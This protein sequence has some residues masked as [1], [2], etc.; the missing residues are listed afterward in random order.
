VIF[1]FSLLG[2]EEM[3][4]GEYTYP[5]WSIIVGW[6]L[7][8]SSLVCIPLYIVYKLIVT[9]GNIIQVYGKGTHPLSLIVSAIYIYVC[10]CKS[11]GTF[12][13]RRLQR[14]PINADGSAT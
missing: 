10:M 4:Q 5:A 13:P 1:I 2:Y 3:L 9:P 11:K 7:T 6:V 12:S 14:V 8:A